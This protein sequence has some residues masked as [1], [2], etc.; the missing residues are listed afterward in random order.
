[1]CG[2]DLEAL[3]RQVDEVLAKAF[4]PVPPPNPPDPEPT[5]GLDRVIQQAVV[6][7]AVSSAK[8]VDT[9]QPARVHAAGGREPRGVFSARPGGR[10]PH[11]ASRHRAWRQG[12]AR[13]G[14]AGRGGGRGPRAGGSARG[15]RHR[16]DCARGGRQ[17][18]SAD[19][20]AARARADDPGP[21]PAPQEQPAARRRAGCRQ[22]RAG[23]RPRAAD[24][25]GRRAGGAEGREGLRARPGRAARGHA[26]PRRLRGAR[27]AGARAARPRAERHPVH[28]RDPL[29]GRRRRRVGR[30]DGRRQPAEAG[31]RRRLAALHRLDD[32]QRREAVVRSRSRAVAAIPED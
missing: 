25:P 8:H 1:M 31:A 28:R 29:A 2:V 15:L 5:A 27:Q 10:P 16:P 12:P 17:D 18:R 22:D 14:A 3:R 21:L 11:A 13:A 20:P 9:G 24:S 4:T 6:H 30:R 19:R 26:L 23:R 7:A 32:V